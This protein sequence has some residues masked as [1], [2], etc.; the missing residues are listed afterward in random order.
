MKLVWNVFFLFLALSSCE[1]IIPGKMSDI[2]GSGGAV[3][4]LTFRVGTPPRDV[5]MMADFTRE[6]VVV[7]QNPLK[8]S[9]SATVTPLGYTDLF[10][11]GSKHIFLPMD[12]DPDAVATLCPV[13]DGI[14]GTGGASPVWILWRSIYASVSGLRLQQ[15]TVEH[16]ANCLQPSTWFCE[17]SGRLMGQNVLI[18]FDPSEPVTR[19]PVALFNKLRN[20]RSLNEDWPPVDIYLDGTGPVEN[21]HL[22]IPGEQVV[23]HAPGEPDTLTVDQTNTNASVVTIGYEALRAAAIRRDFNTAKLIFEPRITQ[24]NMTLLQSI[25]L[26]FLWTLFFYWKLVKPFFRLHRSLWEKHFYMIIAD[27][28]FDIIV[29]TVPYTYF[30][31]RGSFDALKSSLFMFI[32]VGV[33]V[34]IATAWEFTALFSMLTRGPENL[35]LF[36][37]DYLDVKKRTGR[38]P[39]IVTEIGP[40]GRSHRIDQATRLRYTRSTLV[41]QFARNTLVMMSIFII[42]LSVAPDTLRGVM[43]FLIGCFL[44]FYSTL[45]LIT[46][47]FFSLQQ[48]SFLWHLFMGSNL[49]ATGGI[50]A[51]VGVMI[52]APLGELAH[53]YF[54]LVEGLFIAAY[55]LLMLCFVLYMA[56]GQVRSFRVWI[57][58]QIHFEGKDH[59]KEI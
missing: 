3:L 2:R 48:T 25:T 33:V 6:N 36:G 55:F 40:D 12:W 17:T 39:V 42:T 34:A 49:V 58:H 52:I 27:V 5:R 56:G 37:A 53:S 11:I 23:R 13:C 38:K 22:H 14:F 29:L 24:R 1:D 54:D 44:T 10:H 19:I 9:Y 46:T 32:I 30:F 7:A 26:V 51:L 45:N 35:G 50:L 47:L 8:D 28:A 18:F 20:G 59:E 43:F 41:H 57:T 16:G 15:D 4:E 31:Q 21:L